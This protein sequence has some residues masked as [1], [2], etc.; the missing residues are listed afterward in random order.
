MIPLIVDIRL[1]WFVRNLLYLRLVSRKFLVV[2]EDLVML[3]VFLDMLQ[4]RKIQLRYW[5]FTLFNDW[6]LL[7]RLTLVLNFRN[8]LDIL[9]FRLNVFIIISLVLL[10]PRIDLNLLLDD[11]ILNR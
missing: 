11:L 9:P 3:C 5:K 2:K 4:S 7:N 8:Y 1:S 10:D 6:L